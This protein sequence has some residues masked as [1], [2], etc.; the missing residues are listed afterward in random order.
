MNNIKQSDFEFL[1]EI[2]KYFIE[3][4]GGEMAFNVIVYPI[5][6]LILAGL[7]VFF[8][9]KKKIFSR[10]PKYYNWIVKLYIPCIFILFLYVF[11]QLGILR[12]IYKIVDGEKQNVTEGLYQNTLGRAFETNDS[13]TEFITMLLSYSDVVEIETQVFIEY[14]K[15]KTQE[16]NSGNSL[17]DQ[18]KNVIANYIIDNHINEI[19]QAVFNVLIELVNE[20]ASVE[21]DEF[22]S[23]SDINSGLETLKT[24]DHQ[25][26]EISIK[27]KL[28]NWL[29]Q[30]INA[31]YVSLRNAILM[32]LI[33]GLLLPVLEFFVYKKW[34]EP[35]YKKKKALVNED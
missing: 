20:N 17:I 1:W 10:A 25:K 6:G 15:A 32:F 24:L 21:V 28:T 14:L 23:Y 26:I 8:F 31:Q 9:Y 34:I 27:N 2:T 11:G 16:M 18:G 7:C 30:L 19:Y 13:K 3:N 4:H 5:I 12:G 33:L 35:D 22:V 29:G